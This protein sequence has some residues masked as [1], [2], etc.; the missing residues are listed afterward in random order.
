MKPWRNV[1][2]EI[3]ATAIGG[4]ARSRVVIAAV[5][6]CRAGAPNPAEGLRRNVAGSGVGAPAY[7]AGGS[8][9]L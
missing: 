1:A 9:D 4:A 3:D 7:S 6:N 2:E 5:V 8:C